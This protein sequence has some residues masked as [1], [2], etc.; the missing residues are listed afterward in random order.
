M[1]TCS[2]TLM[3]LQYVTSATVTPCGDRG[4]EVDVVGADARGERRA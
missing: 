4:V 2:A 3:L 1:T